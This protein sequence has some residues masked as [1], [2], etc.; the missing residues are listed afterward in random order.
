MFNIAAAAGTILLRGG[1]PGFVT[2]ATVMK[3]VVEVGL[4]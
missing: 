1:H 3:N 2:V 4:L